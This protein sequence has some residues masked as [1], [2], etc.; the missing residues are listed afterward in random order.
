MEGKDPE[1]LFIAEKAESEN[2]CKCKSCILAEIKQH[3]RSIV[4]QMAKIH[5]EVQK[6]LDIVSL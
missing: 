1:S 5:P 2:S 6:D 3:P 4:S